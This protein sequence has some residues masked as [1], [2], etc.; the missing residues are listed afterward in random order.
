MILRRKYSGA[1]PITEAASFSVYR[2]AVGEHSSVGR[3][4]TVRS[5]GRTRRDDAGMSS[6]KHGE[7]PC[8]RK[9]KVSWG[10][11]ILPGLVGPKSRPKGVDDGQQGKIFLYHLVSV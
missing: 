4:H 9:P 10:R 8:H 6:D 1:K 3:S 11:L 2:G 5:G 7:K